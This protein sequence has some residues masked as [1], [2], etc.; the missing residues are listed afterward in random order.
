MARLSTGLVSELR[1]E[2]RNSQD[3]TFSPRD[4]L[5]INTNNTFFRLSALPIGSGTGEAQMRPAQLKM[6]YGTR[7]KTKPETKAHYSVLECFS[8]EGRP[9]SR[10]SI[11]EPGRSGSPSPGSRRLARSRSRSAMFLLLQANVRRRIESA[12]TIPPI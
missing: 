11:T 8:K 10:W 6:K 2:S 3:D 12:K 9:R 1:D 4:G 5:G 7:E